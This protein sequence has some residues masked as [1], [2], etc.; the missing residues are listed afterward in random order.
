[1]I[2]GE[3]VLKILDFGIARVAD[4][5]MTQSGMMLGTV[6]Y[7]SPEQV[8][9]PTV[10]QRSDI[11]AAGA[12][13]Y[14]L[15]TLEQAFPGRIDNGVL[16]RILYEGPTPIEQRVPG[17]D[18]DLATIVHR[19]LQRAPEERYQHIS[20]MG[21]ELARVRRRLADAPID[22][23][24]DAP[25]NATVAERPRPFSGARKSDSGRQKPLSPERFA[26]LQRQQ[27]EEHLRFGE[28][29]FARGDHDDALHYGERA[30]NGRSGKRGC[31]RPDRPRPL[32]PRRESHPG[33]ARR[34]PAPAC[35]RAHRASRPRS[36]SKPAPICPISKAPRSC[37]HSC[38]VCLTTS[39]RRAS[40]PTAPRCFRCRS[41]QE[42]SDR[43]TRSRWNSSPRGAAE[44][45]S[46]STTTYSSR[47]SDRAASVRR[48]G[49]LSWSLRIFRN[50]ARMPK[51]TNWI[52][53]TKSNDKHMRFSD[54]TAPLV[55]R[56]I[57]RTRYRGEVNLH[58][59]RRLRVWNSTRHPEAVAGPRRFTAK[60]FCFA[61]RKHPRAV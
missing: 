38:A 15:I 47:C 55:R 53:L 49:S 1:M 16:N 54:R 59:F 33:A 7:M 12:V 28:A 6:N 17:I 61:S 39:R 29:A 11:F 32:R 21:R 2:T 18:P 46:T 26:E 51:T 58:F 60:S 10:D 41:R 57:A 3:G 19:A 22:V 36:S 4:S 34:G 27:V 43:R 52:Q 48:S 31:H 20:E 37:R 14:E 35:R 42:P 30:S 56:S 45:L 9:G 24:P 8:A 25:L 13:L 44:A 40:F 50:D 23:D 5:G